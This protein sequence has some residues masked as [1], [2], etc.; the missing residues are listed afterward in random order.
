MHN[1]ALIMMNNSICMLGNCS[2]FCSRLLIFFQNKLK[3]FF[4]EHYQS[5]ELFGHFQQNVG[6]ALGPIE[7]V[8]KGY[9]QMTKSTFKPRSGPTEHWFCSR[10]KPFDT[11]FID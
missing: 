3:K 10:P 9:Q 11:L 2:S 1:S 6:P 7:T 5:V 8:F 4:Q